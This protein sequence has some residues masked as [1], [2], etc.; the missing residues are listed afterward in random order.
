MNVNKD[1]WNCWEALITLLSS[2]FSLERSGTF[3]ISPRLLLVETWSL[4]VCSR[5][6]PVFLHLHLDTCQLLYIHIF[7]GTGS[8]NTHRPG[9]HTS[10][11]YQC[12]TQHTTSSSVR[13]DK[14]GQ[15]F[16]MYGPGHLHHLPIHWHETKIMQK[17]SWSITLSWLFSPGLTRLLSINITLHLGKC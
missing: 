5:Y 1:F 7:L 13:V 2:K 3:E 4:Y 8:Q 17:D 9:T 11:P 16:Y 6:S 15:S 12:H 14:W 10:M